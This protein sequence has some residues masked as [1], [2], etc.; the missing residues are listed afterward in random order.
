M[1]EAAVSD[2]GPGGATV[3]ATRERPEASNDSP[4]MFGGGAIVAGGTV[5]ACEPARACNG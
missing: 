2:L 4:A 1:A 3:V 5:V